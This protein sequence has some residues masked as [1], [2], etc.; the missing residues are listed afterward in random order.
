MKIIKLYKCLF[1]GKFRRL[2]DSFFFALKCHF[3]EYRGKHDFG[4]F[5][6]ADNMFYHGCDVNFKKTSRKLQENLNEMK[7]SG[8]YKQ[9]VIRLTEMY[10]IPTLSGT[11]AANLF[12]KTLW[13]K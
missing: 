12:L 11:S 3:H 13:Q 2:L 5:C 8:S 1:Q 4:V 6:L 7:S 9:S 10:F